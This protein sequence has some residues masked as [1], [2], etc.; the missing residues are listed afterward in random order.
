[1][2]KFVMLLA[3]IQNIT[4]LVNVS[5]QD[6]MKA[7]VNHLI[8]WWFQETFDFLTIWGGGGVL[9]NDD[10]RKLVNNFL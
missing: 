6:L 1:M 7:S 8:S 3:D 2:C 9:E 5:F 10:G 4:F